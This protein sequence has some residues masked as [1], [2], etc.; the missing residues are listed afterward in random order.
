MDNPLFRFEVRRVRWLAS[1]EPLWGYSLG[2]LAVVGI[3]IFVGW[4]LICLNTL[5]SLGSRYFLERSR[6]LIALLFLGSVGANIFLDLACMWGTL[7][8]MDVRSNPMWWDLL[9]VSTMHPAEIIHAKHVRAQVRAWWLMM[10]VLSARISVVL[11]VVL[12]IFFLD[13]MMQSYSNLSEIIWL[14]PFALVFGATYIAETYWRM[15]AMTALGLWISA[16]SANIAMAGLAGFGAIV[17]IWV[18]QAVII[19]ILGFLTV[20]CSFSVSVVGLSGSIPIISTG[21]YLFLACCVTAFIIYHYY[22]NLLRTSL[23]RALRNTFRD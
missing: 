13:P 19:G 6:E 12:Q 22:R 5:G 1:P 20:Q 7:N 11:L 21:C 2:I 9:R 15:R 4:L 3:L 10:I 17:V 18:S 16:R 23:N 8:S 14:L